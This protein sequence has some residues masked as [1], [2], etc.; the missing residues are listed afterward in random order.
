LYFEDI[1]LEEYTPS[2]AAQSARVDF[3]LKN[4]NIVIEVKKTRIGLTAKQVANEL[5]QREFQYLCTHQ[6]IS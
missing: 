3:L 6:T 2:N 1:R 4:E 5:N